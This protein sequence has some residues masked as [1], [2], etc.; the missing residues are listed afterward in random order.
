MASTDDMVQ[1]DYRAHVART[2]GDWDNAEYWTRMAERISD[3]LEN[4][5]YEDGHAPRM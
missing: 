2:S 4:A 3:A 1:A 5:D